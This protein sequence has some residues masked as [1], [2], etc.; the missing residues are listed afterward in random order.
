MDLRRG[1]EKKK[2][3][4]MNVQGPHLLL[5]LGSA[6]ASTTKR[7]KRKKN[8]AGNYHASVEM[9]KVHNSSNVDSIIQQGLAERSNLSAW[10]RKGR[11]TF[12]A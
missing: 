5:H 4:K 1:V 3:K 10:Q 9:G 12:M 7:E 2:K 6:G 11:G 8:Q